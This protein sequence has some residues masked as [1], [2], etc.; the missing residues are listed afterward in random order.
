MT[1]YIIILYQLIRY[2][3]N[4]N[5]IR[6]VR[7]MKSNIYNFCIWKRIENMSNEYTVASIRGKRTNERTNDAIIGDAVGPQTA[8]RWMRVIISIYQ[9]L[10]M[11]II[12]SNCK[13]LRTRS[14][15]TLPSSSSVHD[16]SLYWDA[17][18]FAPVYHVNFKLHRLHRNRKFIF[19]RI[20]IHAICH[21][22]KFCRLE[23]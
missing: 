11:P 12:I 7:L 18:P 20:R 14:I 8:D 6:T 16:I 15:V 5:Y 13:Y 3:Y 1:F 4:S 21:Q 23:A 10:C 19:S 2:L 9:L 22:L 17:H